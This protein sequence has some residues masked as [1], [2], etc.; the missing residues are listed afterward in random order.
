MLHYGRLLL[1]WQALLC[2]VELYT[3]QHVHLRGIRSHQSDLPPHFDITHL[4]VSNMVL[5]GSRVHL[6]PTT[7]TIR[8]RY[9]QVAR[10][11]GRH[12]SLSSGRRLCHL[13]PIILA[14]FR[15]EI[16]SPFPTFTTP[17]CFTSPVQGVYPDNHG[18]IPFPRIGSP[19]RSIPETSVLS[20]HARPYSYILALE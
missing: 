2:F 12:A 6:L 19:I 5:V 18:G 3:S 13:H 11:S 10:C 9:A 14:T 20:H 4:S 1:F 16:P 15:M 17:I 7:K 8:P